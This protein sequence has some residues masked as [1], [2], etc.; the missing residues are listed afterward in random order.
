MGYDYSGEYAIDNINEA[1]K[2]YPMPNLTNM[3]GIED[4]IT[5]SLRLCAK[6]Q[7]WFLKWFGDEK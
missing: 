3:G 1:K 7:E 2:D 6:R 5:K 4:H